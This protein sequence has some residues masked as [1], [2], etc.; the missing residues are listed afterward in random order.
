MSEAPKEGLFN[1]IVD[2]EKTKEA[3]NGWDGTPHR[4]PD[5]HIRAWWI[6][7]YWYVSS[8]DGVKLVMSGQDIETDD[9]LQWCINEHARL[10]REVQ[11]PD[12]E[13]KE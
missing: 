12:E 5:I 3:L 13:A 9:E 8:T 6:D 7:P 2:L 11:L 1:S 10:L 4:P